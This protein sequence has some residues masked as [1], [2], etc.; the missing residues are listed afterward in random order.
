MEM[1]KK[2][3]TVTMSEPRAVRILNVL[4]KCDAPTRDILHLID[5]L[6]SCL[7]EYDETTDRNIS[8]QLIDVANHRQLYMRNVE[9][10]KRVKVLCERIASFNKVGR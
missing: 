8:L 9:L 1:N 6:S 4:K 5:E 7:G 2:M 10:E 3:I